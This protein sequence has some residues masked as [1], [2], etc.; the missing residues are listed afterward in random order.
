MTTLFGRDYS[1]RELLDLAGDM[2]QLAGA[3][4]VELVEGIERGS[5]IFGLDFTLSCW[6]VTCGRPGC[7]GSADWRGCPGPLCRPCC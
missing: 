6:P 3:R 5:G 4:K 7:W 2:S 1:R